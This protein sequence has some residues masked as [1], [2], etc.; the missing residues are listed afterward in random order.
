M[1]S[2]FMKKHQTIAVISLLLPLV[3]SVLSGYIFLSVK[4]KRSLSISELQ[5]HSAAV[6]MS[7]VGSLLVAGQVDGLRAFGVI[8]DALSDQAIS[9]T[10]IK[11]G[12][13]QQIL[14]LPLQTILASCDRIA[15]YVKPIE[16][17]AADN[18]LGLLCEIQLYANQFPH[19]PSH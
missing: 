14:P 1:L 2:S 17:D 6:G 4:A 15:T 19:H 18:L 11:A 10:I 8:A 12:A 7:T 3:L 13:E 9:E 16:L 5:R